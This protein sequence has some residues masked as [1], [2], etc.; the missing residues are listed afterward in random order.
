MGFRCGIVGLP[1]VG[2]S[3][4][5]NA[6]TSAKAAAANYPFCTIEPNTGIVPVR[7]KRLDRIAAIFNPRQVV[8]TTVEF[9]DIAGLV[10]DAS[11]GEGLGNQ[12]LGHIREVDAVVQVVRCFADPDVVHVHG[13]IDPVY[14]VEVITTELLLKDLETV[15]KR[16]ERAGKAA[17]VGNKEAAG[18]AAI[19]ERL[20]NGLRGGTPARQLPLPEE[21][22]P[23]LGDL[24][25]LT[26]KPT[27][28]VANVDE[29]A[30][31]R[32]T[33]PIEALIALAQ[34]EG[35]EV[36]PICGTVEA[37]IAELDA[38]DRAAFLADAGLV[39]SGL[40]RLAHAGYRL[41]GLV[42]FFTA[43]EKEVRAWTITQGM[44]APQAAGKIHSDF[45][46]G[47]I[48]AEIYHYDDLIACGSEA[49]VRAKGL[50]RSEGKEYV[51]Q[52]GDVIFFK[53]NV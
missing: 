23:L 27:L 19:L 40:D 28:Y 32:P 6:L 13:H 11:K 8:P 52:D 47:F 39:E 43:G 1:N 5:F 34:A 25:L 41:L 51:V 49:A 46:R 22:A 36:V 16:L 10:K 14:D 45:E 3:T 21:G 20:R 35:S 30:L 29:A 37:E 2:K 48:R 15:E 38:A 44:T 31:A 33:P 24:Q 7:D 42:T 9:L 18:E 4:I 17:K 53:F 12:F 26:A 50:M